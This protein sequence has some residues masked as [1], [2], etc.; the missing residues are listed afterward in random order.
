MP[1]QWTS[2]Q[3]KNKINKQWHL[4]VKCKNQNN[5]NT[6]LIAI[7]QLNLSFSNKRLLGG[8]SLKTEILLNSLITGIV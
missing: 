4:L 2:K 8:F 1:I 7:F 5:R 6:Q 3:I